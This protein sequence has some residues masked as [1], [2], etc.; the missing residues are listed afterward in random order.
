MYVALV[1]LWAVL[2]F[3]WL[4]REIPDAAGKVLHPLL[5]TL[6]LHAVSIALD[7]HHA[8][9]RPIV[10]EKGFVPS[11]AFAHSLRSLAPLPLSPHTLLARSLRSRART[12]HSTCSS[13]CALFSH[14]I[15][16][17]AA[18]RLLFGCL[19]VP[20]AIIFSWGAASVVGLQM[21]PFALAAYLSVT[22]VV[23]SIPR[24][25][26][27]AAPPLAAAAV[28]AGSGA[29]KGPPPLPRDSFAA[30]FVCGAWTSRIHTA[31]LFLPAAF[32]ATLHATKVWSGDTDTV[33]AAGMLLFY[34]VLFLRAL[35]SRGALWHI[36]ITGRTPP[37]IAEHAA[38]FGAILLTGTCFQIRVVL[39]AFQQYIAMRYPWSHVCL[40]GATYS[41][42]IML[43]LH[44]AE[45]RNRGPFYVLAATGAVLFGFLVGLPVLLIPLPVLIAGA[46]VLF[47]FDGSF[48][49]YLAFATGLLA[50]VGWVARKS[51]WFLDFQFAAAPV[52]IVAPLQHFCVLLGLLALLAL[53]VPGTVLLNLSSKATGRLLA[54][55]ALGM[56]LAEL[57]L[58][59]ERPYWSW[60]LYPMYP[61]YLVLVTSAVGCF[62]WWRLL[63][64]GR[65][66][67]QGGWIMLSVH[68]GKTV[69]L[70]N[71]APPLV[72]AVIALFAA[73]AAPFLLYE[74]SAAGSAPPGI[75]GMPSAHVG[76]GGALPR[77]SP[78]GALS[79]T[80]AVVHMGVVAVLCIVCFVPHPSVAE[81]LIGHA[82]M[83][84]GGRLG[85][86]LLVWAVSWAVLVSIQFPQS[87][88]AKRCSTLALLVAGFL[89]AFQPELDTTALIAS[90]WA[91]FVLGRD[92]RGSSFDGLDTPP[93]ATWALVVATL[94][95]LGAGT[96]VLPV[97][98]SD[99]TRWAF[100]LAVGGGLAVYLCGVSM[101]PIVSIYAMHAAS[102]T[103]LVGFATYAVRP[104][105]SSPRFML[106]L[107][108]AF[109]G[110][111]PIILIA[112]AV[113]LRL[114][115]RHGAVDDLSSS[116]TTLVATYCLLSI[117]MAFY[118]K[119]GVARL[120]RNTEGRRP[121][122]STRVVHGS[123]DIRWIPLCGNILTCSA[124]M[125]CLVLGMHLFDYG[126]GAIFCIAPLLLL[127][128]RQE[129][130]PVVGKLTDA[131]RYSP[132]V[133]ALVVYLAASS[134]R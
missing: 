6:T 72:P 22:F 123:G 131:N 69:M 127:L 129:G 1:G 40:C 57:V 10:C 27:F 119:S 41:A 66:D 122:P 43:G 53:V 38:S 94:S 115:P 85:S 30:G 47:Y 89:I 26:S 68:A 59:D 83:T 73:I 39:H 77:G 125:L 107:L 9:L 120:G 5:P 52:A 104:T 88:W 75:S 23:C 114:T 90:L 106:A 12:L 44:L 48:P 128:H 93:W 79:P 118:L 28:A 51:F 105:A 42:C 99:K 102:L 4:A 32:Y 117:A 29:S 46:A 36:G 92:V 64:A 49:V 56:A 20:S 97:L 24:L 55:H 87:S 34:P 111:F 78:G 15:L 80:R 70:L 67:C 65:I 18:E 84:S 98:R 71:V 103:A 62:T 74:G 35:R 17:V 91:S 81:L 108:V 134:L 110:I 11:Y 16:A 45:S 101:P 21:V 19:P 13:G 8:I 133:G 25:S 33:C 37:G 112:E 130:L 100:S 3:Q 116:R 126:D 132:V 113:A 76:R 7:L 2:Q 121:A 14:F 96:A 60:D 109:L 86:G 31:L 58:F 63:T 124:C 82:S 50:L 61:P 54:A 95:L